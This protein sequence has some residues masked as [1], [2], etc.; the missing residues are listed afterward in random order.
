MLMLM[1]IYVDVYVDVEV[2]YFF[3]KLK[4]CL[5]FP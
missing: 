5:E 1:L 2:P 4:S 3:K